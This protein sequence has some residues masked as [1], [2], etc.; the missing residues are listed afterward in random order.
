M[1]LNINL[2]SQKY[3]DAR[4]FYIRWGSILALLIV[5][6]V[7][8][9][10]LTWSNYHRS[11]DDRQRL[12][13]LQNQINDVDEQYRKEKSWL[14]RPENKDVRDQLGFWN[15]VI[16]QKRFSWT[17]LF[18]DLEKIMPGRAY[19][20]SVQPSFTKDRRLKLDLSFIG[21]KHENALELVRKMEGS[22]RFRF[23]E[24]ISEQWK[25]TP[26]KQ[27]LV[28]FNIETYY[29]PVTGPLPVSESAREGL[30]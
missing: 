7:A 23:P 3:Q 26:G 1:R 18:A 22:E 9:G 21:E 30:Q 29:T 2:A 17:Q 14:D 20:L 13:Q 6:T 28:V 16:Y 11:L 15:D 10:F 27:P 12:S 5:A 4:E 24:I 25:V 19:V 8:L